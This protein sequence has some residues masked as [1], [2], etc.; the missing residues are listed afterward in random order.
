MIN[1]SFMFSILC[2]LHFKSALASFFGAVL[3]RVTKVY[4]PHNGINYTLNYFKNRAT[5]VFQ[6]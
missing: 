4:L 5:P 2:M 3:H 1:N 6:K